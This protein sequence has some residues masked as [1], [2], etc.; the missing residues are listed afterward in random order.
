MERTLRAQDL[1]GLPD[2]GDETM[3]TTAGILVIVGLLSV[4]EAGE[5]RAADIQI[6]NAGVESFQYSV[7][8]EGES[9]WSKAFSL[10]G[11][12]PRLVRNS[13]RGHQL[14]DRQT[15]VHDPPARSSLSDPRRASR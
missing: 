14:L 15:P 2:M 10:C 1:A 6:Q 9:A 3:R 12:N 4:L 11:P 7:R 5:T 8:H 13:P